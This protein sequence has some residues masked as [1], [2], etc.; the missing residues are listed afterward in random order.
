[1]IG[2]CAN[3]K[4][5]DIR[6][7]TDT[8]T[9]GHRDTGTQAHTH[10]RSRI[11]RMSVPVHCFSRRA[12]LRNGRFSNSHL[13]HSANVPVCRPGAAI[14]DTFQNIQGIDKYVCWRHSLVGVRDTCSRTMYCTVVGVKWE[15]WFKGQICICFPSSTWEYDSICIYG[16]I[17]YVVYTIRIKHTLDGHINGHKY[18][19]RMTKDIDVAWRLSYWQSGFRRRRVIL[20]TACDKFSHTYLNVICLSLVAEPGTRVSE[21]YCRY[22]SRH[23]KKMDRKTV[24]ARRFVRSS[25]IWFQRKTKKERIIWSGMPYCTEKVLN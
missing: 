13:D 8:R 25:H 6:P 7:H 16:H 10:T 5:T 20:L 24:D 18:D 9:H 23:H 12:W 11:Y 3:N 19:L 15:D 21:T 4:G 14:F 22:I 2:M 1:M 17:S